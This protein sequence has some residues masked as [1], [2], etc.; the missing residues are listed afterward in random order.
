MAD[1]PVSSVVN[2]APVPIKNSFS[3]LNAVFP[4][5]GIH[6]LVAVIIQFRKQLTVRPELKQ[7]SGWNNELN[8]FMAQGL[9]K[10]DRHVRRIVYNSASTEMK[11]VLNNPD[12]SGTQTTDHEIGP[13]GGKAAGQT[14]LEE[15]YAD[16][17]SNLKKE[18]SDNAPD[19]DNVL[20]PPNG[21]R[22]I[23]YQLDGLD[24]NIPQLSELNC[25]NDYMRAFVQG[26]DNVVV[27]AT[28]LDS[29]ND[30]NS[31]AKY[32]NAMLHGLLS[33]LW[34]ILEIFGGENNR[35]DVPAGTLPDDE[36]NTFGGGAQFV[37]PA[38]VNP[39]GG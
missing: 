2:P 25:P 17:T 10:V 8:V 11:K 36:P 1:S 3:G 28:R 4:N 29:R 35:V 6:T 39:T 34:T 14:A 7:Q 33:Q 31:I 12:P 24:L 18:F 37:T 9:N 38:K 20:P 30:P 27:Q 16:V 26:L 32:E 23:P 22:Q 15:T 19:V 21:N 5:V 13:I